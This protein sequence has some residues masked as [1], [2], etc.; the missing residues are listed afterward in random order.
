MSNPTDSLSKKVYALAI[1][2]TG[3]HSGL[4]H[5]T[6]MFYAER[7]HAEDYAN[8]ILMPEAETYLDVECVIFDCDLYHCGNPLAF[9]SNNENCF[10]I[11]N[12]TPTAKAE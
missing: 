11:P 3:K 10:G 8:K 5:N 6:L 4:K 9:I 2:R 12:F 7:Q 1:R